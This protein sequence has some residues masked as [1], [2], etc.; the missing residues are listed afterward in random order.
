MSHLVYKSTEYLEKIRQ[1]YQFTDQANI[2][3]TYIISAKTGSNVDKIFQ[4]LANRL[5]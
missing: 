1:M 3:D 5:I 2:L 4:S